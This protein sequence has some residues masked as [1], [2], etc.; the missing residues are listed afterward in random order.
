MST[1][2]KLHWVN[3][4]MGFW[5]VGFL[6][7]LV[8]VFIDRFRLR[9]LRRAALSPVSGEWWTLLLET[10]GQLGLR[11]SVQLLQSPHNVMPVTWGSV[12]PVILLPAQAD[13][14]PMDRRRVVLLHELAHVKRLDCFSQLISRI[15]CAVYWFNP[16]LWVAARQ[17]CIERERACDD[18]VL[19]G[20]FKAS[21]YAAHLVEIARTFSRVPGM[22]GIAMARSSQLKN[23]IFSIVEGPRSRR[24]GTLGGI[25]VWLMLTGAVLAVGGNQDTP[26]IG[27]DSDTK[28][29]LE[30]QL[31]RLQAFSAAKLKQSQDLASRAGQQISPEFQR[32]FDASTSGD[33]Q[34]VTNMYESFKKRHPQYSKGTNESD[35]AL[36]T[37]YWSPV[38]EICL[39]YDHVVRCTPKYTALLADGI[40]NSIPPG[41]IYFGGTDPG[42]GIPTAFAKSQIDGDPFFILTQNALADGTYLEYLRQTYGGNIYTLTGDDSQK[43]FNDYLSD[44]LRRLEHDRQFP[45]EPKQI[46]PGENV[47]MENGKGAV[48]GQTAVMAINGRLTRM[49]FDKNPGREFYIEESFPLDWMCPYLEPHGLIMKIN[50]EPLS[51]L[52][53]E[54]LARDRDYWKGLVASVLGD[55]LNQDTPIGTV[56]GFVQK[57]YVQN[58]FAGFSGDRSFIQNDYAKRLFSKLRSSIGGVYAWR[59]AHPANPTEARTM[60][61]EADLAFRQA[62]ALCPYSPE[63]VFRYATFLAQRERVDDA[64]VIANAALKLEP[65]NSEIQNLVQSLKGSLGAK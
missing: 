60:E 47:R 50:R 11:R 54:T 23:R 24:L 40:I 29:L 6:L 34:T 14:W 15:A 38:L 39:A 35:V 59:V 42:R 44:A 32:F 33:F 4:L 31:A 8:S 17:M 13:E 61:T 57:V 1:E 3:A 16:L 53:Q 36:S 12:R 20:G 41:S 43:C 48:S 19:E 22:A 30:Q 51:V 9:S 5:G 25:T 58:D 2:L 21:E 56:A 55:W 52:S 65:K 45:L 7:V 37:P 26:A 64:L 10:R 46:R 63:A 28:A 62:F 18:L 49:V 27:T